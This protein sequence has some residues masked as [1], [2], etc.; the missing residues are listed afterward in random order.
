MNKRRMSYRK[1][2]ISR[3]RYNE[4]RYFCLQFNEWKNRLR[5]IE[6]EMKYA[7]KDLSAEKELL[8][9]KILMVQETAQA[10][11]EDL[12]EY[13]MD[14][15]CGN[16]SLSYLIVYKGIPISESAFYQIRRHFFYLLSNRKK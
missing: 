2:G 15:V 16:C 14:N 13:L 6:S 1:Y 9:T 12:W 5:E 8:E 4:L 11:G 10:A 7:G 3:N